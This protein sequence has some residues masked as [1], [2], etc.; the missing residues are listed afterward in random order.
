M[1]LWAVRSLGLRVVWS[2][3]LRVSGLCWRILAPC[4]AVL[5]PLGPSQWLLCGILG[6]PGQPLGPFRQVLGASCRL[7]GPSWAQLGGLW[8]LLGGVLGASWAVLGATWWPLGPSWRRLGSFLGRLG[9]NLEASWAVL[10]ASW[11]LLS[12]KKPWCLEWSPPWGHS[13]RRKVSPKHVFYDT[14]CMSACSV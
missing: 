2:Y 8:S 3:G 12:K 14:F 10:E 9:R 5:E 11:E 4:G 1:S 7:L 13:W 6:R